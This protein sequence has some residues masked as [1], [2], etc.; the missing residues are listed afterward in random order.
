[1]RGFVLL[2]LLTVFTNYIVA[3]LATPMMPAPLGANWAVN[4]G[5]TK[6]AFSGNGNRVVLNPQQG[7]GTTDFNVLTYDW[8]GITWA[9]VDTL[10]LY[11]NSTPARH[12]NFILSDDGSRMVL[13]DPS[14]VHPSDG[15]SA[16]GRGLV[17]VFDWQSQ[18]QRWVLNSDSI[19]GDHVGDEMGRACALSAQG[20]VLV[21]SAPLN[22]ANGINAGQ[23]KV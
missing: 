9:A 3:Q 18:H 12:H 4:Q 10:D 6:F 19:Y 15:A 22:D 13:F 7:G 16:Y 21:T 11:P 8:D 17:R 23:V 5:A 14:L 1:M 20:N 2:V